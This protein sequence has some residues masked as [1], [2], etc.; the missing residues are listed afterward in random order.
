MLD[1]GTRRQLFP[2]LPVNADLV[3]V[4]L[5]GLAQD[6]LSVRRPLRRAARFPG[7]ELMAFLAVQAEDKDANGA[8]MTAGDGDML[9]VRAPGRHAAALPRLRGA[10]RLLPGGQS[11]H[12]RLVVLDKEDRLAVRCPARLAALGDG[13]L[14]GPAAVHHPDFREAVAQ[15]GIEDPLAVR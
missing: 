10:A 11:P 4:A 14:I 15:G 13:F 2:V 1:V 3:D 6:F 12:I 9:T 8:E 5:D 7:L